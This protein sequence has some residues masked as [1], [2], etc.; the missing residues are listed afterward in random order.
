VR[1]IIIQEEGNPDL[2]FV[3]ALVQRKVFAFVVAF[4]CIYIL[5]H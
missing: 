2:A 1:G 4:D 5:Y 3:F